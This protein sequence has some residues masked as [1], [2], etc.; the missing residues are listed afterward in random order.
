MVAFNNLDMA[1]PN[2]DDIQQKVYKKQ[3]QYQRQNE[4]IEKNVG[5]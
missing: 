4:E 3:K 2:D 5:G 1:I